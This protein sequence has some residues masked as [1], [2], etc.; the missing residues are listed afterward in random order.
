MSKIFWELTDDQILQGFDVMFN[1]ELQKQTP[2]HSMIMFAYNRELQ[3]LAMLW[4][5][6][7]RDRTLMK[8]KYADEINEF[9]KVYGHTGPTGPIGPTGTVSITGPKIIQTVT[10]PKINY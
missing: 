2:P 3:N 4:V 8:L 5:D 6:C 7:D 9:K 10:G 1:I